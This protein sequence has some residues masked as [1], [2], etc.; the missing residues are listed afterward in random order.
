MAAANA[1]DVRRR[2]RHPWRWHRI[3]V[4]IGDHLPLRRFARL[5]RQ[6][7]LHSKSLQPSIVIS[8]ADTSIGRTD[9]GCSERRGCPTSRRD[10]GRRCPCPSVRPPRDELERF[11]R[12]AQMKLRMQQRNDMRTLHCTWRV[13]PPT[14]GLV[15]EARDYMGCCK[16]YRRR[17]V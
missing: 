8:G 15:R 11:P 7:A 13:Q 14:D 1:Q 3:V 10:E 5:D 6:R 12:V 2:R 16:W 9:D 4:R 17:G